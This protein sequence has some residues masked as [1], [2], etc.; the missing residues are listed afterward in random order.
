M[1][2]TFTAQQGYKGMVKVDGDKLQFIGSPTISGV[3]R[4]PLEI[5]ALADGYAPFRSWVP[6]MFGPME[7]AGQVALDTTNDGV[8]EV[9]SHFNAASTTVLSVH[10][11]ISG[12]TCLL[13]GSAYVLKA[14][15]AGVD[16]NGVQLLDTTVRWTASVTGALCNGAT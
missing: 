16:V 5:T 7:V 10:T 6:G 8:A 14:T 11:A 12:G 3:E 1:A 4:D 2:A 9:I 13:T 15:P